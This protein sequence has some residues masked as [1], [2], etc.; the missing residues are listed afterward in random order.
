MRLVLFI[1]SVLLI[2]CDTSVVFEQNTPISEGVWEAKNAVSF[3]VDIK[4]TLQPKNLYFNL[5][6]DQTFKYSNL[7]VLSELELPNGKTEKDT[8]EFILCDRSGKWL[9]NASGGLVTHQIMFQRKVSF[10]KKGNY[11]FKFSQVMR[12]AKLAGIKEV[13]LRIDSAEKL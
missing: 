4:E 6:N 1:F 7:Y 8:L 11:T 5:R 10:P 9:G 3:T 2:S 12:D 13:G